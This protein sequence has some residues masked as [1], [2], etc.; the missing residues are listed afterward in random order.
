MTPTPGAWTH[1]LPDGWTVELCGSSTGR[2][3]GQTG[4]MSTN[5]ST[6]WCRLIH[7]EWTTGWHAVC[8][9]SQVRTRQWWL[10]VESVPDIDVAWSA[11][12]DESRPVQA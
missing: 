1:D 5:S 6:L 8:T 7:G 3:P 2:K 4:G 9:K 12:C 11:T 10:L